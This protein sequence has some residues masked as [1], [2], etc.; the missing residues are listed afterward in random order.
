MSK[1]FKNTRRYLFF[2][3]IIVVLNL[4]LVRQEQSSLLQNRSQP[5]HA[6][7]QSFQKEIQVLPKQSVIY[8]D[9]KQ[10]GVSK[11]I[12]DAAIGAGSMSA[13]TSF[14]VYYGL[15]WQDIYLAETFPEFLKFIESKKIDR[16][17]IYTFFYSREGGLINT[18]KEVKT[19]LFKQSEVVKV[20]NLNDIK[21]IY[22][23]PV[24]LKFSPSFI[25]DFSNI[26]I[27]SNTEVDLSNYLSFLS[28]RNRY[29]DM[30]SV[31]ASSEAEY[32]EIEN[33]SDQ[34]ET[35]G[36]RGVDLIWQKNHKEEV[37]LNLGE[38]RRI[39][40]I[41][42]IP[43]SIGRVPTKYS[44]ECSLDGINWVDLTNFERNV[45]KSMPFTDNFKSN[46]S[47][48]KLTIYKTVADGPPQ[49]SEI[50][51]LENNFVNL[52]F[53]LAE[54]IEK[55]PF[56]FLK[57]E[58]DKQT[59]SDYLYNNG[60]IG[61]ICIHTNK[62]KSSEPVCKKYKFQ[63][64]NNEESFLIDQG[65]TMIEKIEFLLPPQIKLTVNKSEIE[66]QTFDQLQNRGYVAKR[67]Y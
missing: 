21:I 13:T 42:V 62:H 26:D 64:T 20:V 65:G 66:Y 15:E 30:V 12:R 46:C 40:G 17:S 58:T 27:S 14:A 38:I 7:W 33:I 28:S 32:A 34:D 19:A 36:W 2:C 63:L 57:S 52:D 22:N 53:V 39:G 5:T 60:L 41:R 3:I 45:D 25:V 8:I 47:F 24:I 11:P 9:S 48:I 56:K 59:L 67:T 61:K 54:E 44:Y 43:G 37:V 35:T 49:I 29:W 1:V 10:D 55:N 23:S 16:E 51:I 31:T 18:T 4:V 50:E 6:F